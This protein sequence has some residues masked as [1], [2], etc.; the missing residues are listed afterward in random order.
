[1]ITVVP[2]D[3]TAPTVSVTAP[4]A[5][6]SVN[7]TTSLTAQASDNV[8]V[9][10]VKF[11]VD[12]VPIGVEDTTSPYS[13]S[14]DSTTLSNGN[15]TVT[16][17]AR[18]AAGNATT[19]AG[20]TFAV[21]NT[22]PTNLIQNPSL[23][24]LG[25]NGDPVGWTRN[26]WG[27]NTPAYSVV[28]GID[29]ARAVRVE[30]TAYSSGD[31]KWVFADVPVSP[32]ATYTFSDA[33][34]SN[35][36][37][38]L[39]IQYKLTDGSFSYV[40]IADLAA[41]ANW[42]N[43]SYQITTPANAAAMT[44]FH[45]IHSVGW[46]ET[47]KFSL[48]AGLPGG[49]GTPGHGMI[50]LAFDDGWLSQLQNAVPVL[51][52]ANLPASFYMIT[53]AN[54]GGASWEEVLN[55]SL[56]VAGDNG[57]PVNWNTRQTGT[58]TSVF[59]YAPG[60]SDGFHSVRIDVQAYTSGESAWLFQDV[61]VQPGTQYTISHQYNSN[62][63]TSDYVRFTNHNGTFT[64]VDL[65]ALPATNGAWNTQAVTVT[66]PANADAMTLVHRI[67]RVG[68]L[69]TDNYSVK[70]VDAFSNPD[71]MTPSQIQ[72]LAAAGYEVGA[73]TMTHADLTAVSAAGALAE[74]AGSRADL[75][76]LGITPTTFVY[77]YGSYST[78]IEQMVAAQ[79]FV[80][81]RTVN[82]GY[83]TA[84]TDRFALLHHEVDADT[85]VAQVQGWIDTA[86]QTGSWLILTFHEVSSSGG[87]YRTTPATFQQIVNMVSAS[88]LTPVTMAG[89]LALL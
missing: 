53:R 44:V 14:L 51:Q 13:V 3:T 26:G 73:H 65:G 86:A 17:E 35:A 85:T 70:Q 84:T 6:A 23:E 57:Q 80:G 79:G 72:S 21:A 7:G 47:D 66:A 30:M 52:Q 62:V 4:A 49:G 39:V 8:G 54:Q 68:T 64:F 82:D 69:I 43:A 89:G 19:S 34:R 77:P 87:F 74:V 11:L 81:A 1:M 58:N 20:V 15:H 16:A 61:M 36:S 33:Y 10:G 18:D 78:A 63:S 38:Q 41:A 25:N 83:N 24:N 67:T 42:T 12:G 45:L 60:G 55:P 76:N 59:N 9:V 28:A 56:E 22:T 5:N 71:Y 46:L 40:W 48:T 50:T 27:T 32:N 29:G 31:A 75:I 88:S 2:P 37:S